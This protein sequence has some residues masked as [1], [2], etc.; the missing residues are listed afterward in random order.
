[1]SETARIRFEPVRSQADASR[2]Q[3]FHYVVWIDDQDYGVICTEFHHNHSKRIWN[4]TERTQPIY[5]RTPGRSQMPVKT[6]KWG[7]PLNSAKALARYLVL[8]SIMPETLS[9]DQERKF[10]DSLRQ[11][12]LA[13][14]PRE[15]REA[16][17]RIHF[18][19]EPWDYHGPPQIWEHRILLDGGPIATLENQ[20]SGVD[21]PKPSWY[22]GGRLASNLDITEIQKLSM[23]FRDLA[24]LIRHIVHNKIDC[25]NLKHADLME[26]AEFARL[27]RHAKRRMKSR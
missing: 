19:K 15:R 17:R 10:A 14:T 22:M 18:R 6:F 9:S 27:K 20:L 13:L 5:S 7:L 12:E 21:S 4:Y 24:G 23:G 16:T 25:Q 2:K 1:M 3:N 26:L 11:K 8:N